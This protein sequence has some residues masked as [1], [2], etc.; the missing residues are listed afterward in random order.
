MKKIV[1]TFLLGL[2][3]TGGL[4]YTV[5]SRQSQQSGKAGGRRGPGGAKVAVETVTTRNASLVDEGRFV[6]SIESKSK[7]MVAP[8]ISG[9]LKKLLVDIGDSVGNGDT[10]ATLDDEELLLAVKQAEAD[11]EIARANVNESSELLTISQRELERINTMRQQK[12]SSDVDVENAQA[13]HKTRQAKHQVN[14]ALLSQKEAALETAKVRLSYA[15]V[16]ASWSDGTNRRFI[17]ERFLNEGAMIS[18]NTP[19]ASVIDIATVTAVIDVVEQDYFKIRAGL[20]A[21][22]EPSALPGRVYQARISRISPMLDQSS[23]QAR[24]ELELANSDFQLKPGMFIRAR[25]IYQ[26]HDHATVIPASALVRRNNREGIF[27]IN[28]ASETANFIPVQ[29]GFTEGELVEIASPTINGEVVTLGHHL[30]EDGMSVILADSSRQAE[31]NTDKKRGKG[32]RD[33]AAKGGQKR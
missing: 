8:K 28:N 33:T 6:G 19:I 27:L 23:R 11:L 22:I 31:V 30:L 25:I 14:R 10:I 26:V 16:D 4:I 32:N 29:K 2:A 13:A 21:E 20:N 15:K 9:R 5:Q 17:A 1:S 24:I 18:A 12:V 7:F 3:I